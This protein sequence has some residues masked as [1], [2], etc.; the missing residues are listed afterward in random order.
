MKY[1]NIIVSILLISL[2]SG[3]SIAFLLLMAELHHGLTEL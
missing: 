2:M 1:T 3:V